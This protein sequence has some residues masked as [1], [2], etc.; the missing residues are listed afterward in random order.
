[1]QVNSPAGV[2][3]FAGVNYGSEL[4]P[5]G[6]SERSIAKTPFNEASL[7]GCSSR[8]KAQSTAGPFYRRFSDEVFSL[9]L[10]W[11]GA[12]VSHSYPDHV[13]SVEFLVPHRF[14]IV[15]KQPEGCL[16]LSNLVSIS[17]TLEGSPCT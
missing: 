9:G 5:S 10:G 12:G 14:G 1:M 4:T 13:H 3:I 7:P 8:S 15:L 17:P 2:A 11:G 6:E 16:I